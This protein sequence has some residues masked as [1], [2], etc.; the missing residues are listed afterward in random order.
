MNWTTVELQS[1]AARV[2]SAQR[3]AYF[4]FKLLGLAGTVA[5]CLATIQQSHGAPINYG[6]HVGNTVSYIDVTEESN[7]GD[8]L[9]LFGAPLYS[10]DSIDFNPVGFDANST[11]GGADI[12]D[13]NLSFGVHANPGFAINNINFKESGDTT[14]AGIGTDAT[15]TKVTA[16]GVLSI[17]EVDGQLITVISTPI[18]L[19]FTPSAGDFGLLTDGGGGPFFHAQWFGSLSLNIAQILTTAGQ[20]FVA[21]ATK[22]SINIDN[23]LTAVSQLG[24]SS[25]I[26]KKDFGGVSITINAPPSG[27]IPEPATGVLAGCAMLGLLLWRRASR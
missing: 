6:S 26:S 22:I 11:G 1:H 3:P 25:L 5:L 18:A 24:T 2:V 13:S 20:P 21:G 17:T 19:T 23:T 27:G 16:D 15:F 9:P 14:L 12:T 8:T 10:A 4:R 7:S